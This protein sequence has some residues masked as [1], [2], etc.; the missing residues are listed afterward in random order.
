MNHSRFVVSNALLLIVFLSGF[1]CFE[2]QA[3][4][5][6]NQFDLLTNLR[7]NVLYLAVQTDLPDNTV[8][9]VSVSR[10]YL[11]KGNSATCSC[12]YLSEKSTVGKWKSKHTVFMKRIA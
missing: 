7:G 8:L 12:D 9:M 6:C 1:L 10:S 3:Q 2:V 11:E 5:V 4:V